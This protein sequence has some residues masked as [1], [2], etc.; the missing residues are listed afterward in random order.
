MNADILRQRWLKLFKG[1]AS[2]V[3]LEEAFDELIGRYSELHRHY[4][5]VNHLAACL[6]AFDE[7]F[8]SITDSFCIEA[9]L[10]FHDVVY[11]PRRT[12]NEELSAEYWI[13][14]SDCLSI[15]EASIQKILHLIK[16]TKH[17]SHPVTDDEKYL[18]D[19]DLSI[20]GAGDI[21]Y[22]FYE[23]DIKE[24]YSF[25]TDSKYSEGRAE[26]LASFLKMDRIYKTDYF[27]KRYEAQAR[28]NMDGCK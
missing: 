1:L 21:E 24:E 4:H 6:L 7:V 20:L 28:K 17:P 10:W 5:T 13:S 23:K 27:Y 3:V 8:Q 19:I 26:L 2:T 9:A 11:D 25:V 22:D 12:N 14:F 18:I 16:L 15:D